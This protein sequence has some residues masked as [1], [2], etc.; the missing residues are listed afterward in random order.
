MSKDGVKKRVPW[1][2]VWGWAVCLL[3]VAF[4][5]I[6]IS[7]VREMNA[8]ANRIYEHPYTV[9]NE[10]RSMRSRLLDMKLFAQT[11][12]LDENTS[13]EE[14]FGKRY[15]V[16][17][18]SIA[19]IN[20]RYLGPKEDLERLRAAFDGLKKAQEEAIAYQA[21]HTPEETVEY[22]ASAV[23]PKYD[24]VDQCL[25]NIIDFA[26]SK[27]KALENDVS[28][29]AR[30]AMLTFLLLVL[31]IVGFSLMF[32]QREKKSNREIRYREALFN[33]LASN[34]DD[35][36]Y[37]YNLA[38]AKM[39]F[40]SAN[41]DRVLGHPLEL[42][43]VDWKGWL[44]RLPQGE[45]E[46]LAKLLEGEEITENQ[47]FEFQVLSGA[48]ERHMRMRVYP[49]LEKGRVLRY[50]VCLSDI[51]KELEAQ[52]NLR[53]A[54]ALAQK[55]NAAKSE[56]LSRMSHEIRTPMN[57]II[58]MTTIAAAYINDR[59]KVERCL[60]KISFSSKHLMSLINDVL[61]MSKIEEGKLSI[62]HEPFYLSQLVDSILTIVYPQA[63]ARKISFTV[64]LAGVTEEHLVGDTL[65][66]RQILLNLLSNALKFTPEGGK[67]RLEIQQ[68]NKARDRVRLRFTVS[69]TGIG[70]SEEFMS[71]IFK[72]FEQADAS[73]SQNY[74]GTGLGLSITHNLVSLMGG[75]IR[76]E[77]KPGEG[78]AFIVELDM[79]TVPDEAARDRRAPE[80][81]SLKVLVADDEPDACE[82]TALLLDGMGIN[83]QW[84]LT[85]TEA[86]EKTQEAHE[87]GMDFDV[88]FI[89]WK[90]PDID[91]IETTR[92]IREFVGPDTLIIIITAYDWESIEAEARSAG[93]NYFLSKPLFAS[94]LYD[95]L[96]LI[97]RP[98]RQ[99]I[100]KAAAKA[101]PALSGR[102]VLLAEDNDLN[103]EIAVEILQMMGVVTECA[104]NGREAVGLFEA[105]VPGYF[106]AIL[107]DIQMPV[108]DGYEATKAIRHS[109]HADAKTVPILA[110]TANAFHEDVV[111]ALAAG[112]DDHIAKPIDPD[113]LCKALL[114]RLAGKADTL[115]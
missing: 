92:R 58:G 76:V 45:R 13:S 88:C 49:E 51:T 90:M 87:R 28:D 18:A 41:H 78:T 98:A 17:E 40:V 102:R 60:G 66:L 4:L 82:H 3:I 94:T 29:A 86:I 115:G 24:E 106:D 63:E 73:T 5:L 114:T 81:E 1:F 14:F 64:P 37:I 95:A 53:N 22:V 96:T 112:M 8:M 77:S 101:L 2:Q 104:E 62:V 89:D 108:M 47:S 57:A 6:S 107:M 43:G 69:D 110:M 21:A 50:I 84:V 105:S 46:R 27:V 85:G 30:R 71:R 109:E 20:E 25:L 91:G 42:E 93:A 9:S 31:L 75:V 97:A 79:D 99:S 61:D 111:N 55:A 72:P 59:A 15:E 113:H 44:A 54:L 38:Q 26:D 10:A 7:F 35:V 32:W 67:I 23:A 56:F 34:I 16:Q 80:F 70:M 36:F 33:R 103:R 100:A 65:R 68:V 48:M 39:E 19:V 11:V 74:G 83:A 12:L 52:Q